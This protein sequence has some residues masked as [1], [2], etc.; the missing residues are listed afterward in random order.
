MNLGHPLLSGLVV[1]RVG[2]PYAV[3]E[4]VGVPYAACESRD[5]RARLQWRLCRLDGGFG[6]G[7]SVAVGR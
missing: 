7:S 2:V 5:Q 4:R 1:E 6:F 3:V